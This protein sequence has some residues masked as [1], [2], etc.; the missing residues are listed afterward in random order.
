MSATRFILT[1]FL[2]SLFG[3]VLVWVK[4]PAAISAPG[5]IL[6]ALMQGVGISLVIFYV[7]IYLRTRRC[8]SSPQK[9]SQADKPSNTDKN[10][11]TENHSE[12]K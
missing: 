9:N 2:S 4:S 12:Q 10:T 6:R 8:S 5:M 1:L 11:P 7:S 3:W